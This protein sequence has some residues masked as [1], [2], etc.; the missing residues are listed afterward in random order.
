MTPTPEEIAR[1][2]NCTHLPH[3]TYTLGTGACWA[4]IATALT[5]ATT[6][7]DAAEREREWYRAAHL[8]LAQYEAFAGG[9]DSGPFFVTAEVTTEGQAW[10]GLHMGDTFYYACADA[11]PFSYEDAPRLLDIAKREGWPGLVRYASAKRGGQPPI[12]PVTERMR[13]FDDEK[14]ARERAE[15]QVE[16]LKK[17][18]GLVL[19]DYMDAIPVASI[20]GWR[21]TQARMDLGA[22]L[23]AGLGLT[24]A[25]YVAIITDAKAATEEV[26]EERR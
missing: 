12:K 10:L 15:A 21:T 25:E 1:E 16:A 4:C 7:A 6:R 5:A 23:K 11:E 3:P 13:L 18:L 14:A 22:K 8:L 24:D 20:H 26:T 17:F 9:Q 2:I 19:L